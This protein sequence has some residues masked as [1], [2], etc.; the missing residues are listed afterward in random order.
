MTLSAHDRENVDDI[1]AHEELGWFTAKLLRLIWKAD[2][3]HRELLAKG[4]PEEVEL[5]R[6]YERS[7]A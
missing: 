2:E 6:E 1:L 3:H 4:F 7:K 5:V